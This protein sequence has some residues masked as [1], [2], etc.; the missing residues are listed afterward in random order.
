MICACFGQGIYI[1]MTCGIAAV[2]TSFN[3][4]S[5]DAIEAEN[6]THHLSLLNSIKHFFNIVRRENMKKENFEIPEK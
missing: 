3:V 6:C 4:F 5:Y 1:F 2:D